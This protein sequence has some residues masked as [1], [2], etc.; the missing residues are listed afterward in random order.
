MFDS[1]DFYKFL[2]NY[3]QNLDMTYDPGVLKVDTRLTIHSSVG[4]IIHELNYERLIHHTDI[5]RTATIKE[6][7]PGSEERRLSDLDTG[8]ILRRGCVDSVDRE[9]DRDRENESVLVRE[10]EEDTNSSLLSPTS[11]IEMD[12]GT[13]DSNSSSGSVARAPLVGTTR[14]GSGNNAISGYVTEN[15]A[16]STNSIRT[17]PTNSAASRTVSEISEVSNTNRTLANSAAYSTNRTVCESP[18]VTESIVHS[19]NEGENP[20]ISGSNDPQSSGEVQ[21]SSGD[22]DSTQVESCGY[23]YSSDM[24]ANCLT[25]VR[26]TSHELAPQPNTSGES[27]VMPT[28]NRNHCSGYASNSFPLARSPGHTVAT[29]TTVREREQQ[30]QQQQQQQHEG[31]YMQRS[32][33]SLSLN[34]ITDIEQAFPLSSS[35]FAQSDESLN[36][37]PP[38]LMPTA[39]QLMPATPNLGS[40]GLV[41]SSDVHSSG[42]SSGYVGSQATPSIDSQ[43][44]T[45]VI[46]NTI[47]STSD[48]AGVSTREALPP[49]RVPL[50]PS[51]LTPHSQ[52]SHPHTQSKVSNQPQSNDAATGPNSNRDL[53]GVSSDYINLEDCV[54]SPRESSGC[55]GD[56]MA[57]Q[58]F[59]EGSVTGK[60]C[61]SVC[62]DSSSEEDFGDLLP[63][64]DAEGDSVAMETEG[65][66]GFRN[67]LFELDSPSSTSD[68]LT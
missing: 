26:F 17:V 57:P 15:S 58:T 41:R 45:T 64:Y 36:I 7:S 21:L 53:S 44:M 38:Q 14:P 67:I 28:V 54:A 42:R 22:V 62:S 52:L 19:H 2:Y 60:S 63:G 6:E 27:S 4:S 47:C 8:E 3:T 46:A 51:H 55:H 59:T 48:T 68:Y 65:E 35:H 29:T 31:E 5:S 61:G 40:A 20:V 1:K 25:N 12:L 49:Y 18:E 39:P 30:R 24:E 16:V 9:R 43:T 23:V 34:I 50:S 13:D 11:N 56:N 37:P 66:R 33:S 32:D 10:G